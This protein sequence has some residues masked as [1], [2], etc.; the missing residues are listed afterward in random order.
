MIDSG[1]SPSLMIYSLYYY[2]QSDDLIVCI[3][4]YNYDKDDYCIIMIRPIE[5]GR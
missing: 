5:L 2:D 3:L 4:L 1:I